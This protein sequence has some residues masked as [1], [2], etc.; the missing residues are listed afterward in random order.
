MGAAAQGGRGCPRSPGGKGA[1]R[2]REKARQ[3]LLELEH[4]AA[5]SRAE[6]LRLREDTERQH[7]AEQE[8][9]RQRLADEQAERE[10]AQ[11]A[12]TGADITLTWSAVGASRWTVTG[13]G[14]HR[15]FE[16]T[17]NEADF[18]QDMYEI[19]ENDHFL[20]RHPHRHQT[21]AAVRQPLAD[22][23]ELGQP[24][25]GPTPTAPA[26]PCSTGPAG[27]WC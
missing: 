11:R 20:S 9:K 1:A 8:A 12:R 2:R 10:R 17:L 15:R 26:R 3:N 19:Q 16:V 6:F 7:R 23:V 24:T 18:T 25:P 27:R 13:A 5:R 4:Q 21:E 14:H 22:G